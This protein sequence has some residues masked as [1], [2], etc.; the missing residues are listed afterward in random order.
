M[1]EIAALALLD[2]E[3]FSTH[4][5]SVSTFRQ[6]FDLAGSLLAIAINGESL[7]GYSL[8]LPAAAGSEGWFM[9]LGVRE[10]LRRTGVGRSL[11]SAAIEQAKQS[12]LHVLRLTVEP[13]NLAAVSLYKSLGFEAEE[14]VREYFGP[15]EDRLVMRLD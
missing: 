13:E 11:A 14:L 9:A 4:S 10:G 1:D 2:K 7:A 12:G 3:V 6:F 8:I 5:Y 15:G